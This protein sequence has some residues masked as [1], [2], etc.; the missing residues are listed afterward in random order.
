MAR[1]KKI[2]FRYQ[3]CKPAGIF[4][5]SVQMKLFKHEVYYFDYLVIL[6]V[7]LL[8]GAHFITNMLIGHYSNAAET[9]QQVEAVVKVMEANP[10]AGYMMA[11]TQLKIIFSL[12]ITPALIFGFYVWFRRRVKERYGAEHIAWIFLFVSATDFLNDLSIILGLTL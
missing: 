12:I 2:R 6:S 7:M 1:S 10:V 11:T 9:V 3:A 4:K 8:W 5:W